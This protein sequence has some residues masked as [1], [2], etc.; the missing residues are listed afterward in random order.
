MK[1]KPLKFCWSEILCEKKLSQ[2]F[3][4][5]FNLGSVDNQ[6]F[7]QVKENC[8]KKLYLSNFITESGLSEYVIVV[9]FLLKYNMKI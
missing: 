6:C 7:V 1:S 5:T 9:L 2:N 8:E 4:T 3:M